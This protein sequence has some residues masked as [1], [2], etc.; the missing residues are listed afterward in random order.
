[1]AIVTPV[2]NGAAFI[3]AAVQSVRAQDY[4]RLV[5]CVLDNASTD[6]TSEILARLS[7]DDA[8]TP[9]VVSRN[10]ETLSQ[11]DNFNAVLRHIPPEAKY[12]RLL[13][14]DDS[15]PEGAIS[16][17]VAVAESA[18]NVMM[19]AGVERVNGDI[20]PHFFPPESQIFDAANALAR[21]LAD[22]ARI[23]HVHVLYRTETLREGEDFYAPEVNAADIDTVLR[24]LSRGGRM[25]FVHTP[26]ADTTHH[27]DSRTQTYDREHRTFIWEKFV[28]IERYG[29]A[30]L[31]NTEFARLRKRYR[32]IV[33]RR[34]LWWAV[35][36]GL[37]HARRDLARLRE[38]GAEPGFFDYVDAVLSWPA[39]VYTKSVAR[40]HEARPWP[41]D[42]VKP[43]S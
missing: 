23:P 40:V 42:A 27:P 16:A 3:E 43:A 12:F 31:S 2:Y 38:R 36:G 7:Q 30:A 4:P 8:A 6:A 10:N 9:L 35:S 28:F 5:H 15:I 37:E 1:V 11:A 19:T 41:A 29:P 17:M 33:Y 24:V 13:C 39:H 32:R 18:D 20:R 25:G 26:I 21:I 34:M 14:A 22:E